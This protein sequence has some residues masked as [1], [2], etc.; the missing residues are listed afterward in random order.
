MCFAFSLFF[1][2]IIW[3]IKN[4]KNGKGVLFNYAKKQS[5]MQWQV[6]LQAGESIQLSSM[7]QFEPTQGSWLSRLHAETPLYILAITDFG[8]FFIAPFPSLYL[9]GVLRKFQIYD[10]SSVFMDE[11]VLEGSTLLG[12]PYYTVTLLMPDAWMRLTLVSGSMVE[13]LRR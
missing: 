5:I 13:A 8:R 11:A 6:A 2:Y 9:G 4:S 7:G 12:G 1:A 10:R 3:N